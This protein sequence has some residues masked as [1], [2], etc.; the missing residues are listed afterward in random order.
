MLSAFSDEHFMHEALKDATFAFNEDEIPVGAVIV[1]NNRIIARAHNMTQKLN[2]VTAHAEMIA[3][4]SASSFLNSKYLTNCKLYVTLEPCV[5]CAGA[6]F[7]T[8]IPEIIF[9]AFDD[10]R[11]FSIIDKKILHPSTKIKGGILQNECG[12]LLKTYFQKK[13]T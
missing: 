4:T 3:F 12:D 10:K 9:G 11:G 8:Q 6:S 13:R 7:W 2:D 5:M 1:C